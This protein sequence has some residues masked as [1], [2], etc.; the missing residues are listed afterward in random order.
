MPQVRH[1]GPVD[2]SIDSQASSRYR[3]AYD[4]DVGWRSVLV[5]GSGPCSNAARAAWTALSTSAASAS[6]TW[7][8][9]SPV[10]GLTVPKVLPDSLEIQRLLIRSFVAETV[11]RLWLGDD[12]TE[13]IYILL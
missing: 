13:A 1:G 9:S 4:S 5:A 7:Q 12:M 6:A 3:I 8:I 2:R 10:A 11:T